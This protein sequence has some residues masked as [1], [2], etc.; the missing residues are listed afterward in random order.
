MPDVFSK[1]H[2]RHSASEGLPCTG[3]GIKHMEVL[4]SER[5]T[6]IENISLQSINHFN[7]TEGLTFS[8]WAG[9]FS[10]I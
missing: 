3:D 8:L 5:A 4:T 7:K 10:S 2:L 6:T 1:L 9:K